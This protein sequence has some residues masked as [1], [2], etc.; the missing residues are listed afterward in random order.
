M[1]TVL[2]VLGGVVGFALG[3]IA[4]FALGERVRDK[5]PW[6]Y[7]AL[8]AAVVVLGVVLNATG[9]A[10]NQGWLWVGA[11]ALVTA[12]LAGLKYGRGK[13]VGRGSLLAPEREERDVPEVW[14]E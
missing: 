7:W 2:T 14:K 3:W 11:L 12:G 5:R 8:N 13:T 6:R 10:L 1:S 9:L 4:G